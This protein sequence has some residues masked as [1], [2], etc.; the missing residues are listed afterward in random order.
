MDQKHDAHYSLATKLLFEPQRFNLLSDEQ[1]V[2]GVR[3]DTMLTKPLLRLIAQRKCGIDLARF[4]IS[5]YS[6]AF[7]YVG[8][9]DTEGW[10]PSVIRE[11]LE[12]SKNLKS[13]A[14]SNEIESITKQPCPIAMFHFSE[15]GRILR[16][17]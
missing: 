10:D 9:Y 12:D 15:D 1:M 16:N 5:R 14:L 17:A 4:A 7:D 3:F 11:I 8:L 13:V 2:R 6:F